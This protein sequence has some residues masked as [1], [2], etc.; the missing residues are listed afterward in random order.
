[1]SARHNQHTRAS[2]NTLAPQDTMVSLVTSNN[3][4][5]ADLIVIG[6]G[7][8]GCVI[9]ARVSEHGARSVLLIEAGPDYAEGGLPSDLANGKRNA[10]VSHDWG[11]QHFPNRRGLPFPLPRGRV[12]GGS[13]AV[14]TCIAL[15]GQPADYDEWASLG[16]PAWSWSQCLPAFKRLERDLDFDDAWHGTDGPLPLR[17]HTPDEL[18]PWQSAFIEACRELGFTD[19]P[20][21]NSPHQHGVGPYPMNKLG[22]RRISVADAYLTPEVRARETL[23]IWPQTT[24]RRIL[25]EGR[26]AVGVEVERHGKITRVNAGEIV[27][28]GGAINT[29][30]LLL[31]SG[32][33]PRRELNLL[34]VPRVADAPGVGAQLLDHPGSAIF[35]VPRWG[36]QRLHEPGIQVGLRFT[37]GR[38]PWSADMQ[39]QPGSVFMA[40]RIN[41]PLMSLMWAINKPQHMG[42]LR[43]RSAHPDAKPIVESH[44]FEN[45]HDLDCAADAMTLARELSQTPAMRTIAKPFL[46][47]PFFYGSRRRHAWWVKRI[48]DS[49]YHPCGTVAMGPDDDPMAATDEQGRVR[50]V[51]GLRVGDASLMPTIPSNNINL[52]TIMI[53]ERMGTWLAKNP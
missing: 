26:R 19:C 45:A 25:F 36:Q 8:S 22:G 14:N 3:T 40:P 34:G 29:P 12:M 39:L 42:R 21:H 53:G 17:R 18:V 4:S 33:G 44:F 37:S 28:C 2:T 31:R 10:M 23:T 50:G 27:V 41:L 32:V 43:W 47:R 24:V 11:Y 51:K 15:R 49:G 20:D 16:L 46:P 5:R 1:M 9:A 6:A 13:S 48:C 35:F 7:S 52:P 30:G 38:G